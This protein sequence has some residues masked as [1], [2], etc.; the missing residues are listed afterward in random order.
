MYVEEDDV[1]IEHISGT[2][3]LAYAS[4]EA[5]GWSCTWWTYRKGD[6]RVYIHAPV[7][8]IIIIN[9][10]SRQR[11]QWGGGR[12]FTGICYLHMMV[13]KQDI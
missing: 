6:G 3:N 1:V 11:I 9:L 13:V 2:I 10:P 5:L 4:T 7:P 12:K 8:A